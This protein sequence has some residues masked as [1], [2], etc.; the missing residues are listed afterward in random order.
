MP[1]RYSAALHFAVLQ[2]AI[3]PA[4]AL[5]AGAVGEA[6]GHD[7]ALRLLLQ[8]VVADGSGGG[9]RLID[10]V[11]IDHLAAA[12]LVGV[13]GPHAGQAIGLQ[14]DP[15]RQRHWRRVCSSSGASARPCR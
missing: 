14:L 13:I 12:I 4:H 1:G 10:V 15:H 3:E 11:F 6:V 5:L 2:A 9:E 8:A 7:A